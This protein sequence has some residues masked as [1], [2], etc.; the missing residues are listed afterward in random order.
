[1]QAVDAVDKVRVVGQVLLAVHTSPRHFF[2]EEP[3]LLLAQEAVPLRI[4]FLEE[5][6]EFL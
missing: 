1:M 2:Y 6:D 4:N 3:E 5:N